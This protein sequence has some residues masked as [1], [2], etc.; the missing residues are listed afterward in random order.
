MIGKRIL[1]IYLI[2]SDRVYVW[3]RLLCKALLIIMIVSVSYAVFG[4]FVLKSTPKWCEEISLLCMV[5]TCFLSAALAIKDDCHVR[6]TVS[7]YLFPEK[8]CKKLH[9]FAYL[10]LILINMVWVIWGFKLILLSKAARMA[11][12]QLP[13][14][15]LYGAAAVSGLVGV[16]M[17]AARIIRGNW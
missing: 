16:L 17:S 13:M 10:V 6:M 2:A 12:T 11:S 8:I 15:C 3:I 5:W 1:D 9:I 14:A 7:T 4:R